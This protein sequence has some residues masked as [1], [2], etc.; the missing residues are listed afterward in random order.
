M[1]D[2]SAST[3]DS[4]Y[5]NKSLVR[6]D[7]AFVIHR[8]LVF[9]TK[10]GNI[11]NGG[12][13]TRLVCGFLNAGKTTYIQDCIFNDYFHKYGSVLILCFEDG[14][15]SYD[16]EKLQT[17]RATVAYYDGDETVYDFCIQSIETYRPDRIYVEMNAMKPDLR[18]ELPRQLEITFVTLWMEWD[19]LGLYM[20]NWRQM[21]AEMVA[22]AGQVTFRDCPSKELLMPYSQV[23]RLMNPR[24]VYLRQDPM[25][26]HERAFDL[27]VPYSLESAHIDITERD[28]L[29]FFLDAAD[30]PEH[31]NGKRLCF[32]D[33][34]ELR[35]GEPPRLG[36]V[37]MTCCMADLQFMS[38]PLTRDP[39]LT[40]WFTLE[41]DGLWTGSG[42]LMLVPI[43]L[44]QSKPSLVPILSA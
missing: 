40:G 24:A 15:E 9:V 8:A 1:A 4:A 25:G 10:G 7:G 6:Q 23:F 41:A 39:N 43:Q 17:Y 26:Y 34:V 29:A 38:F 27:F 42:R 37:V 12:I 33:P 2:W 19:T 35:S 28:F 3:T 14:E 31:Y 21:I 13:D 22:Q 18:R 20:A 11:M 36:R 16:I 32:T 30:H 5:S 44:T